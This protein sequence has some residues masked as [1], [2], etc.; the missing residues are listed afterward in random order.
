VK[1]RCHECSRDADSLQLFEIAR[2]ADPAGGY[3]RTMSGAALDFR[4]AFEIGTGICPDAAKSHDD[5]AGRPDF[6]I[7]KDCS[8][9]EKFVAAK[10]QRENETRVGT[11]SVENRGIGLGFGA[12]HWPNAI[13]RK[14]L[15]QLVRIIEPRV[16]PNMGL[17]Q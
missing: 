1:R 17:R 2:I 4:Q 15:F 8:R 7:L 14:R 6:C 5:Y 12:E 10:I 9:S 11:M 3:H 13:C 16:Q